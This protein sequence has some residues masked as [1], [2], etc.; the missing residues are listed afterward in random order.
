MSTEK[1]YKIVGDLTFST[2]PTLKTLGEK[3]IDTH[4][5][6]SFDFAFVN[7]TDSS[8]IALLLSWLRDAKKENKKIHFENIPQQVIEVAEVCGVN[9][10]LI[11]N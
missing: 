2:V 9:S 8:A 1:S 11:F 5:E 4:Q 6:P 3:Y 7:K 10:L